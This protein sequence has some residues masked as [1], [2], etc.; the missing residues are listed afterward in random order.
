MRICFCHLG[1]ENLG[2]EYLSAVLKAEGHEVFLAYDPGLFG[3]N[4]NVLYFPWLE[5]V[6]E[7]DKA[8]LERIEAM[9]PDIVAFS[10]YT[11]TYQWAARMAGRIK[12]SIDTR[13]V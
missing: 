7:R 2:I 10:V 3:I 12:G 1:R 4:D 13:T 6:F 5:R 11:G 9:R 8:L